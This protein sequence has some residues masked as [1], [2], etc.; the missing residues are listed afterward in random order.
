MLSVPRRALNVRQFRRHALHFHEQRLGAH[1]AWPRPLGTETKGFHE[2]SSSNRYFGSILWHC[3]CRGALLWRA[4]L[5]AWQRLLCEVTARLKSRGPRR[6]NPAGASVF[7]AEHRGISSLRILK[8]SGSVHPIIMILFLHQR[9]TVNS[10][11]DRQQQLRRWW[12]PKR[13]GWRLG[14]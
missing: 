9:E 4:V 7:L 13:F 1:C 3:D 14:N 6:R 2:I 5:P 11:N 10:T 8:S 12:A